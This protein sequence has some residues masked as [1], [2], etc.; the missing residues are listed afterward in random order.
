MGVMEVESKQDML[1]KFYRM[2]KEQKF[3]ARIGVLGNKDRRTKGVAPSNAT[4]GAVHEYGSPG[5][6][7]PQRSFLRMPIETKL[8][9]ELD[10]R[11]FFTPAMLKKMSEAS[12]LEP[13]IEK[14]AIAAVAVVLQAFDTTGFGNWKPSNMEYKALK[15]TLVETQQLIKSIDHDVVKK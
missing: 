2:M 3:V 11:K 15:Q 6:N 12:S 7:I 10:K 5:K 13:L 8:Q 9:A 1:D 14:V 4:I